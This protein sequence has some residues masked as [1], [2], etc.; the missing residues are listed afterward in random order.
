MFYI[1]NNYDQRMNTVQR[2]GY[3]GLGAVGVAT[4][5][6][7]VSNEKNKNKNN[8]QHVNENNIHTELRKKMKKQ[9]VTNIHKEISEIIATS[10]KENKY[11]SNFILST[12]KTLND[13]NDPTW[14]LDFTNDDFAKSINMLK[15]HFYEVIIVTSNYSYNNRII[16]VPSEK[17]TTTNRSITIKFD[18]RD[19]R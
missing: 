18:D 6:F 13:Y 17:N 10:V 16:L 14:T 15:Q 9:Y 7:M 19:T 2:I 1:N 11:D 8:K 4:T 5:N 3:M 12:T